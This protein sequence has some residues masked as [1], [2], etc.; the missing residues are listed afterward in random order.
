MNAQPSVT[1][2]PSHENSVHLFC[3]NRNVGMSVALQFLY[4]LRIDPPV[5]HSE[6]FTNHWNF[7]KHQLQFS[8][9]EHENKLLPC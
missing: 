4:S 8:T 2:V 9:N 7:L 5:L 1:T 6:N 3:F